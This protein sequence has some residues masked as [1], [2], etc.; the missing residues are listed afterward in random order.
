MALGCDTGRNYLSKF[1]DDQWLSENHLTTTEVPAHSIG[2][3]LRKRGP[4][5]LV[6]ISPDVTAEKAIQLMEATGISQL[7]VITTDGK[8]VGSI[9]EV[10]LVA[11]SARQPRSE[12]GSHQ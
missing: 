5:Q 2:D 12:P 11:R 9:Q 6:K 1:F 7:P 10:T 4:R 3:L 8:P